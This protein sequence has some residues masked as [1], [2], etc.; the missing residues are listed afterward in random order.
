MNNN[1]LI[2]VDDDVEDLALMKEMADDIYF[3][4]EVITFTQPEAAL[5]YLQSM[6]I[7]PLLILSDISMPRINGWEFRNRT[8]HMNS[9]LAG[10]PFIFLSSSKTNE[11]VSRAVGL[12]VWGYYKKPNSVTGMKDVLENIMTSLNDNYNY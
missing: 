6:N 5:E 3:P 8:M 12:N 1:P 4:R 2:F 11:E 7:S 10:T 9:F